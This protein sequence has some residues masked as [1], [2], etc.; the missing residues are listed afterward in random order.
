MN[1]QASTNHDLELLVSRLIGD[2]RNDDLQRRVSA[3][4][5]GMFDEDTQIDREWV[6]R[7]QPLYSDWVRRLQDL[8]LAYQD[9]VS[10]FLKACQ[11]AFP[12][13]SQLAGSV[14]RTRVERALAACTEYFESV[15]P[16]E[17]LSEKQLELSIDIASRTAWWSA[18]IQD[19]GI[20][21]LT[22]VRYGLSSAGEFDDKAIEELTP[23]FV[24]ALIHGTIPLP[25][26]IF[27]TQSGG[28]TTWVWRSP[29]D[30]SDSSTFQAQRTVDVSERARGDQRESSRAASIEA[31]QSVGLSASALS[32]DSPKVFEQLAHSLLQ[33]GVSAQD[34]LRQVGVR[35]GLDALSA[36]TQGDMAQFQIA[37]ST[38]MSLATVLGNLK[39]T[40]AT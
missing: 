27:E 8:E 10:D 32:Q 29:D 26:F 1:S 6:E 15:I 4:S 33:Q 5:D 21:L 30:V 22:V 38:L 25:G 35:L 18:D 11:L 13:S 31:L 40:K 24:D 7:F 19:Q 20:E 17:L 3:L 12:R 34:V 23:F 28:V 36:S 37:S 9:R 16:D 2:A 14:A 39:P